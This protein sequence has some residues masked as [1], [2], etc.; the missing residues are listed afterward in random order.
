MKKVVR[1]VLGIV[2]VVGIAGVMAYAVSERAKEI[3]IR[4]ALG[5]QQRDVRTLVLRPAAALT[6]VGLAFGAI[7]SVLLSGALTSPVFEV[8]PADPITYA[9][10]ALLFVGCALGA[11][12]LPARRAARLDPVATLR[13]D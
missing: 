13:D 10:V 6:V 4:M 5:A 11:A 12:W 3:G 9:A 8:S 1:I 7:L 2:L